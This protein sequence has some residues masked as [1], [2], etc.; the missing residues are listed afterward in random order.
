MNLLPRITLLSAVTAGFGGSGLGGC[1]SGDIPAQQQRGDDGST[2]DDGGVSADDGS[3]AATEGSTASDATN[4]NDAGNLAAEDGGGVSAD[5]ASGR[6]EERR[7][8]KEGR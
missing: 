5:G 4:P 6:S 1:V 3:G 7:V 8:G 2:L